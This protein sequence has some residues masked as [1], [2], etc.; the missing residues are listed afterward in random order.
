MWRLI[1]K[2]R[3][4][5]LENHGMHIAFVTTLDVQGDPLDGVRLGFGTTDES[6]LDPHNPSR[7]GLKGPGKIEYDLGRGN[8][9]VWVWDEPTVMAD[10]LNTDIPDPDPPG[11]TRFYVSYEVLFQQGGAPVVLTIDEPADG[12][13]VNTPTVMLRGHGPANANLALTVNQ[14]DAYAAIIA[15]DGK[16]AISNINL[17]VG[18]ND[19]RAEAAEAGG[20]V[21]VAAA[22][23]TRSAGPDP[24][25]DV[26]QEI[27]TLTREL[28]QVQQERQA[29]ENTLE[30]IRRLVA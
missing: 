28:G 26:R 22:T 25:A 14:A 3:L 21:L 15:G 30:Q 10:N 13:T 19:L 5:G 1:K 4:S 29:L 7:S 8:F 24:C 2:R 16:Y 11:S 6:W 23:V 9:K 17:R 20:E 27:E 12:S 18:A